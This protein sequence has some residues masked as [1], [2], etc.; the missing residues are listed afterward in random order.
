MCWQS[1]RKGFVWVR[2]DLFLPSVASPFHSFETAG[3]VPSWWTNMYESSI[4]TRTMNTNVM[5]Q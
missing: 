4:H 3:R 5:T 1:D 2:A